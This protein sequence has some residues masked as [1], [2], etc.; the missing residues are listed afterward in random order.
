MDPFREFNKIPRLMR[1]IIVTEKIDG[2]NAQVYIVDKADPDSLEF[3]PTLVTAETDAYLMLAGSRTRYI[4]PGD[5]NFGFATW[6]KANAD[7]LWA[8]GP[9]RHFGEWWGSGIQRGYGLAKGE[10][11]WSL[12]NVSKWSDPASRPSCCGVV[13]TLY[14]GIFDMAHI[15]EC[16]ARLNAEGSM[17]APG[18]KPAEGI[19]VYHTALGGYFKRTILN[20]ATPKG[21]Q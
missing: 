20:D 19:V 7:S 11:H 16:L 2:T 3:G 9:G 6:V 13:P 18:F 10:R 14:T 8:L 15:D 1:D 17:A 12:F 4:K 5:D 21:L